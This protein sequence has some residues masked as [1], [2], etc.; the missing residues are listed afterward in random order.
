ML[1]PVEP[2]QQL[3]ITASHRPQQTVQARRVVAALAVTLLAAGGEL[4]GARSARSLADGMVT[5]AALFGAL[6]RP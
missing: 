1:L 6:A 4:A 2:V 3:A 5:V